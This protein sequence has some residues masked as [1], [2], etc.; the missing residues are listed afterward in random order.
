MKA[1]LIL[2]GVAVAALVYLLYVI[3]RGAYRE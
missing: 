1:L 3:R 2:G